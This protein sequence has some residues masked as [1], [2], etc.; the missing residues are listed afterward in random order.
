MPGG[1][2]QAGNEMQDPDAPFRLVMRCRIRTL[3]LAVQAKTIAR[4][5]LHTC[6]AG[7]VVAPFLTLHFDQAVYWT[8]DQNF[9]LFCRGRPDPEFAA[10]SLPAPGAKKSVIHNDERT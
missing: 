2:L 10:L 7:M 1:P 8:T 6:Q 9:N 5:G 4:A 3:V